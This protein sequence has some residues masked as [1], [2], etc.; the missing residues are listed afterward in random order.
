M[1]SALVE[2]RDFWR[3]VF[4]GDGSL[5]IY[6]RPKN[7]S[8]SFPQFR[9]VG[10]RILL[11]YFLTFFKER[12][13]RG[14]SVRPHK[15]IFVVGTTCGP[16]VKITSLLYADAATSLRRKAEM[17]ARIIVDRTARLA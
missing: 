9:L 14:L 13:V 12:G 17:A 16:A 3:G 1:D 2:S 10:R 8:L 7:P 15:S 11:E 6:K 4:D 5:G